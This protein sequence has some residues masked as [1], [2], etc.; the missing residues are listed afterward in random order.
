MI[1]AALIAVFA[2]AIQLVTMYEATRFCLS[3]GPRRESDTNLVLALSVACI[4]FLIVQGLHLSLRP[5]WYTPG[6]VFVYLW[7]AF[8]LSNS[9]LYFTV[10]KWV[11]VRNDQGRR[12]ANRDRKQREGT[13]V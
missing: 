6:N 10:V 5:E 13:H 12:T 8:H 1:F 9:L 2:T 11:A 4:T 7:G 3:P